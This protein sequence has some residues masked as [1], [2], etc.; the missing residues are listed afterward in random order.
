M[1]RNVT[2][3]QR[4]KSGTQ[5]I[6]V[7]LTLENASA[8]GDWYRV[9]S[10]RDWGRQGEEF[11]HHLRQAVRAESPSFL[12]RESATSPTQDRQVQIRDE[13]GVLRSS[14]LIVRQG[15]SL[16]VRIFGDT[17]E[18]VQTDENLWLKGVGRAAALTGNSRKEY[19]WIAILGADPVIAVE[20]PPFL[21]AEFAIDDLKLTPLPVIE[22]TVS[23]DPPSMELYTRVARWPV[24]VSGSSS[25]YSWPDA[26]QQA[27]VRLSR[28]TMLM[29]VAT[30]FCLWRLRDTP[31]PRTP[32]AHIVSMAFPGIPDEL[33]SKHE[34]LGPPI[35]AK[36]IKG[37]EAEWLRKADA[38]WERNQWLREAVGGYSVGLTLLASN[39]TGSSAAFTA[40]V[41]GLGAAIEPSLSKKRCKC[42]QSRV[43]AHQAFKAALG[44]AFPSGLGDLRALDKAYSYRSGFAHS[45][46]LFG[47]EETLGIARLSLLSDSSASAFGITVAIP[48]AI[49]CRSL[50]HRAVTG[51]LGVPLR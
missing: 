40:A 8:S 5:S 7:L 46:A 37:G 22:D 51:D 4:V 27:L 6:T 44:V 25:T 38:L 50:L 19:P 31:R 17:S 12:S 21:P 11:L 43:G 3:L 35:T 32:G 20:D 16:L 24:A 34:V 10:Q 29:S 14:A 30:G 39:P 18:T 49:A 1:A 41:E 33:K 42:G 15:T 23:L 9:T 28:L 2:D 13:S 47:S 45:G 26:Q 36:P 48:L